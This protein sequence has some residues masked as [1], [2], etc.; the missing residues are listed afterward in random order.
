MDTKDTG[1][2]RRI[3]EISIIIDENGDAIFSSVSPD[4]VDLIIALD[5]EN[6]RFLD[7]KKQHE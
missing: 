6:E 5:N 4:L 1:F 7:N 2:N 3:G